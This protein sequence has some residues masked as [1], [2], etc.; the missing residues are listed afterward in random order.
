[1]RFTPAANRN[2]AQR[3][4]ISLLEV[5]ISIFVMTVG[6][7][8]LAAL[9]P[10]G[11]FEVQEAAK[12]DRGA[13]LAKQAQRELLIRGLLDPSQWVMYD[14]ERNPAYNDADSIQE[15]V[16]WPQYMAAL[17]SQ[18]PPTEY[19][20]LLSGSFVLDPQL[21]AHQ[22]NRDN[23]FSGNNG[24]PS[25]RTFPFNVNADASSA[26]LTAAPELPRMSFV[27]LMPPQFAGSGGQINPTSLASP[28]NELDSALSERMF[29]GHDDLA[30]YLPD[31]KE[32]RPV[33]QYT[34][35]SAASAT[36]FGN[37]VPQYRLSASAASDYSWLAIVSPTFSEVYDYSLPAYVRGKMRSFVVSV[38]VFYKR[39]IT[40]LAADPNEAPT[41]R[42]V[43]I[44]FNGTGI[45]GGS[46]RLYCDPANAIYLRDVRPNQWLLVTG[47]FNAANVDP[48]P[49]VAKWYRVIAVDDGAAVSDPTLARR[50]VTLD[51]P[52][53][54]SNQFVDLN[55]GL[56]GRQSAAAIIDGVVSVHE[57]TV[58]IDLMDQ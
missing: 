32:A 11:R 57:K 45:G 38:V 41:E 27:D 56:G 55:S 33:Q 53:W 54:D 21:L 23:V 34:I 50:D 28:F 52:D 30:F 29:R 35:S 44:T 46:V 7:L 49:V 51:G 12:L 1:M 10:I 31:D 6:L 48:D 3:H 26:G 39:P 17:E 47:K 40:L 24:V 4:G 20:R 19:Q 16:D 8:G 15:Y 37:Q 2:R 9:I 18:S 25:P 36:D 43:A 22:Q 58:Q 13:T 42:T 5:L 14:D